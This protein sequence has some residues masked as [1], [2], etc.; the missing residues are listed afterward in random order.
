MRI[1][2]HQSAVDGKRRFVHRHKPMS[3]VESL[4]RRPAQGVEAQ[5]L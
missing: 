5:P 4:Q 1:I 2:S 3:R